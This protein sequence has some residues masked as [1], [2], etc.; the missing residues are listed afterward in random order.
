MPAFMKTKS[1]ILSVVFIFIGLI[2]CCPSAFSM[3]FIY[4]YKAGDKY[5][6]VSKVNMDIFVDSRGNTLLLK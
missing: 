1:K 3:E 2:L 5:R 6:I 4:K